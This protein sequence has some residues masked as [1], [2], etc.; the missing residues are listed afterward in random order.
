MLSSF[1]FVIPKAGEVIAVVA[2]TVSN[3]IH[4]HTVATGT[5]R[6]I[7]DWQLDR[8]GIGVLI[9]RN[10]DSTAK[11]RAGSR[12]RSGCPVGVAHVAAR[13]ELC[14]IEVGLRGHGD[15]PG[16]V[17]TEAVG[18]SRVWNGAGDEAGLRSDFRKAKRAVRVTRLQNVATEL[19]GN[20]V[21]VDDGAT[22]CKDLL[23]VIEGHGTSLAH[24]S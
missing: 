11:E 24:Y 16:S 7:A 4:H 1:S 18:G 2:V 12:S 20:G 6:N 21:R 8:T 19:G 14:R 3:S 17:A 23:H 5:L 9:G 15:D 13:V 22:K 10:D